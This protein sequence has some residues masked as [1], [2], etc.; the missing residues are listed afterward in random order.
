MKVVCY[1]P[2]WPYYRQG[3]GK[4]TVEDI[5][6]GLCTHIMYSFVVL[7]PST[8]V[9]KIHDKWLDV[10]LGNLRK[11]TDL[12]KDYPGVKFM[13]ALGGW[14]DSREKGLYST[15][16]ASPT[17][18]SAFVTHAVSFLQQY[19]FD[20]LDLDYEYPVDVGNVQSDKPGF[21]ALVRELKA[22]FDPKGWELTAAVS[23]GAKTVDA[24]YEVAELSQLLDAIHLMTYDM[25]GSWENSV[26]H[27]G[28]L[29]GEPGD[30]LTVDAA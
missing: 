30:S 26:D 9:M 28:T 17:K 29:Y 27:H 12:K 13:L 25:H 23:A 19:G 18:R 22:A 3:D 8:H 6:P 16:L 5:E 4:Y 15:L 14:T 11:F 10:D 1:Y 21:T 20:G 7:D 2:N 24:G